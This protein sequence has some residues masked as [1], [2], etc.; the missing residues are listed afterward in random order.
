MPISA[1]LFG[2]RRRTTVPLVTQAFDWEHGVF[3]GSI[4]AQRD[5][6]RPAGRRR[7]A[8]LRPDGD[9]AVLRLQH[10]RLLRPL[11]DDRRRRRRRQPAEDLLRQLV[12]PRRRRPL[13]VARLRREQP[14]AE[15][16][17][18]ARRRHGRRRANRHRLPADR[19][20]PRHHRPRRQRRRPGQR[21]CRSTPRAGRPRCRRSKRTSPSSATRLPAELTAPAAPTRRRPRSERSAGSP[22]CGPLG[23]ESLASP[24]PCPQTAISQVASDYGRAS[25]S[26]RGATRCP[27]VGRPSRVAAVPSLGVCA[28]SLPAVAGCSGTPRSAPTAR[29]AT[30]GAHSRPTFRVEHVVATQTCSD[31]GAVAQRWRR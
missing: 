26:S 13:P 3:L 25:L 7:Q 16:G 21:C 31:R 12:P 5:H 11:A 28:R 14:R 17:V 18:R 20:R 9:A 10:G 2:G 6:R 24:H 30:A 19:R 23:A 27:V 22:A 15:V 8:A 1:I 4:M 29:A